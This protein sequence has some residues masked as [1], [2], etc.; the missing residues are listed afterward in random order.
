MSSIPRLL[1]LMICVL[2]GSDGADCNVYN[3]KSNAWLFPNGKPIIKT[4]YVLRTVVYR[5]GSPVGAMSRWV[6]VK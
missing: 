3:F 6:W 2:F 1:T 4:M 5:N